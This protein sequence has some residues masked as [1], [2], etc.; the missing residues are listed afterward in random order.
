MSTIIKFTKLLSS[1]T[2]LVLSLECIAQDRFT[3]LDKD[4]KVL[5]NTPTWD[6]VF[7]TSTNLYWEVKT[8]DDSPRHFNATYFWGGENIPN[9]SGKPKQ[10]GNWNKLVNYV[11]GSRLCGFNDWR[12]PTIDE[13]RTLTTFSKSS[14]GKYW[15][16]DAQVWGKVFIDPSIFPHVLEMN[17]PFFWSTDFY[18]QGAYGFGFQFGGDAGVLIDDKGS[19]VML[20]RGK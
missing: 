19:R 17:P 8:S 9:Y 5:N 16:T 14:K 2:M 15:K 13:L 7:D 11:N 3:K 20:V 10:Y 1:V 12:V 6:V 4:C 18:E